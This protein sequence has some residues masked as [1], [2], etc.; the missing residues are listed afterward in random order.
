M[1][2]AQATRAWSRG[3]PGDN[4]ISTYLVDVDFAISTDKVFVDLAGE[5]RVHSPVPLAEVRRSPAGEEALEYVV[6]FIHEI[7]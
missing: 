2:E 1:A 5:M 3:T 4:Q 7:A 6:A